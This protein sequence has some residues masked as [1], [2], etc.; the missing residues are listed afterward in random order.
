MGGWGVGGRE[1]QG[2][3]NAELCHP[4]LSAVS[5]IKSRRALAL[6]RNL[7]LCMNVGVYN[8]IVETPPP[9]GGLL[10]EWF[11]FKRLSFFLSFF[12]SLVLKTRPNHWTKRM[13]STRF[14][15]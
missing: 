11:T 13:A 9:G 15:T 5:S 3:R 2:A 14:A 6:F 7:H 1:R 4:P 8:S 10:F 12:L